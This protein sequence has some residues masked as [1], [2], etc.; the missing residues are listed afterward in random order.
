VKSP[1]AYTNASSIDMKGTYRKGT[2]RDLAVLL[3]KQAGATVRKREV[4]EESRLEIYHPPVLESLNI[5][6]DGCGSS[7]DVVGTFR[8]DSE[9]GAQGLADVGETIR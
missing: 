7:A 9:D 5:R 4:A 3:D 6:S 8:D 2:Y 1:E